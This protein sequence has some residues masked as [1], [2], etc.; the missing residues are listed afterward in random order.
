MNYYKLKEFET[1]YPTNISKRLEETIALWLQK[2]GATCNWQTLVDAIR[3]HNKAAADA[4][5]KESKSY[6]SWWYLYA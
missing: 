3:R 2:G 4:I 5:E 1:A 6:N